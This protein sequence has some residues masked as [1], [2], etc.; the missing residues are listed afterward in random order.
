MKHVFRTIL[1]LL[2]LILL[3]GLL[4]SAA[5][6][7]AAFA[8]TYEPIPLDTTYVPAQ[9]DPDAYFQD[10]TGYEDDS[11]SVK[12]V[13]TRAYDTTILLAYITI[14]DP[15][16]IRTAIAGRF[17]SSTLVRGSQLAQRLQCGIRHQWG[18]FQ[19][20]RRRLHYSSGGRVSQ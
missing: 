11:I 6:L 12:I 3:A 19:I 5:P 15:S 9:P 18:L 17:S 2:A 16:Q 14:V 4:P 1:L 20:Y 10:G 7:S 8:E 13:E